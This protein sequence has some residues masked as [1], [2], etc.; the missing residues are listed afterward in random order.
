MAAA[1]A[2]SAPEA[3]SYMKHLCLAGLDDMQ[4]RD[5]MGLFGNSSNALPPAVSANPDCLV[6]KERTTPIPEAMANLLGP[7]LEEALLQQDLSLNHVRRG[8]HTTSTYI[9]VPTSHLYGCIARSVQGQRYTTVNE[10][11]FKRDLEKL[12]LKVGVRGKVAGVNVGS[13]VQLP[14]V[15]GLRWMIKKAGY[16]TD[17][18][19]AKAEEPYAE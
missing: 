7:E 6:L 14:S 4:P 19:V 1:V 18:E 5:G 13:T 16:L 3:I 15:Q 17:A 11:G 8:S 12:G 10:Q 2:L 9:R